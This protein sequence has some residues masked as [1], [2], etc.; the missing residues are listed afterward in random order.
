VTVRG[1]A[2]FRALLAGDK[3]WDRTTEALF[4]DHGEGLEDCMLQNREEVVALCAFIERAGIR[5]YLEVGI[6]TGRLVSALHRVFDF[7]LVATCDHG[8]AENRGLPICVPADARAFRGESH[9]EEYRRW[10]AEFGHVDLVLLDADHR[11][12]ALRRDFE[13]NRA[14]PHRFI[15]LHDICGTRDA[16]RDVKRIWDE[17]AE[18][19]RLELVRPHLEL[20]LDHSTMGIGVWSA[21]ED[22][23]A[24]V[25][26]NR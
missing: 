6:W 1:E 24:F 4:Q 8:Y 21:N 23:A 25:T 19:H 20:G 18:G 11:L 14:F 2:E 22:P 15:A 7:D 17:L 12:H 26:G 13:T 10:R 16:T 5:S 3:C 9:S